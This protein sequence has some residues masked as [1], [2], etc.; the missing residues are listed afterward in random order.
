MT[1]L[2]WDGKT[3]AADKQATEGGIK[4]KVTKIKR[5]AK[6]KFKGWLMGGSGP[7]A[8]A[9]ALML[10]FEA[11][12]KEDE[13]PKYQEDDELGAILT[14]ISPAKDVLRYEYTH[15]PIVFEEEKFA[16]GSGRD[17]AYGAMAMGADARRAVAIT[18]DYMADCGMGIDYLVLKEKK[19]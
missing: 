17:V 19:Q 3:L 7:C 10:W 16:T 15:V 9:N 14:V 4:R 2:V 13:F 8:Q 5:C 1:V 18:C 6:G 12:A 11:G